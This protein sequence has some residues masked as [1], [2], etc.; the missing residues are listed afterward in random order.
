M[1]NKRLG[2]DWIGREVDVGGDL[3]SELLWAKTSKK[4]KRAR[5]KEVLLGERNGIDAKIY[6]QY[7]HWW[8]VWWKRN[9]ERVLWIVVNGKRWLQRGERRLS[10]S[11]RNEER[12]NATTE[13]RRGKS[14][15]IFREEDKC[16][17]S[18]KW[19][20]EWWTKG[21]EEECRWVLHQEEEEWWLHNRTLHLLQ[22]LSSLVLHKCKCK[23]S[24]SNNNSHLNKSKECQLKC[25][26]QLDILKCPWGS[27]LE[28]LQVFQD[29]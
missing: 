14:F 29:N 1:D 12:W 2:N 26:Y 11:W 8:N 7:V 20:V 10:G 5:R 25:L 19:G 16:L 27:N 18:S 22:L 28:C 3:K 23:D 15:F 13:L 4:A 21:V 6:E 17:N 9:D 24:L